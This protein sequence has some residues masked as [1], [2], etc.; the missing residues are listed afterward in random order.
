MTAFFFCLG[1][2]KDRRRQIGDRLSHAGARLDH[3][4]ALFL[5]GARHRHRHLL[6]LKPILEVLCPGEQAFLG[7]KRAHFSDEVALQRV[8]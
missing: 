2:V 4:M 6:L 5:E 8:S 3:Q 7:K 1:R